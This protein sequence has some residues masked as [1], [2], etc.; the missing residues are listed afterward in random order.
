MTCPGERM[1]SMRW[2][3]DAELFLWH[4]DAVAW[5]FLRVPVDV[6]DEIRDHSGP[7]PGFGSVRVSATIGGTTWA[8]SVFPEKESGSF[9]LPVKKQVR[10]TECVEDGDIAKV[11]IE[12]A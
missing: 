12:L 4:G 6:A 5:T 10:T 3:F 9:L 2:T 8:M 11:T 7:R 1:G